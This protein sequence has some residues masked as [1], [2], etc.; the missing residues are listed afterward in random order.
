MKLS[1][2]QFKAAIA[3]HGVNT[4]ID[5]VEGLDKDALHYLI[6]ELT[7]YMSEHNSKHE[8]DIL[9]NL[10]GYVRS[11]MRLRRAVAEEVAQ[12]PQLDTPAVPS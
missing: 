4:F 3:L 6:G 2:R 8:N 12:A 10:Q 7:R 5:I 11:E 9:L 1:E